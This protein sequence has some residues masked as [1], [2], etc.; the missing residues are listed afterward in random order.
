LSPPFYAT[1]NFADQDLF[2]A[3]GDAVWI[4]YVFLKKNNKGST[5]KHLD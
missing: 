4:D 3:E 2:P 1:A 5:K